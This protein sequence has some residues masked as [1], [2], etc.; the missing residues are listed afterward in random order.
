MY[1]QESNSAGT[2]LKQTC[3]FLHIR[4]TGLAR[5][6]SALIAEAPAHGEMEPVSYLLTLYLTP[7]KRKNL[8]FCMWLANMPLLF[9]CP[10][11]KLDLPGPGCGG[12]RADSRPA[13]L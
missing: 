1:E 4:V 12:V 5:R 7:G 9:L 8:V 11:G 13:G 3:R 10:G 2:G 6:Q